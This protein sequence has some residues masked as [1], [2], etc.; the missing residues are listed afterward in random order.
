MK[1]R[2]TKVFVLILAV[3][4]ALTVWQ[5]MED[6]AYAKD[7]DGDY[8]II[9][10]PG[11]GGSDAGAVSAITNDNE[12]DL[13]WNIA[14]ALKAELQ[15]YSGVKVY[16]TRGSAEF[17]SNVG[18]AGVGREMGADYLISV[19]NNSSSSSS[20]NGIVC[21]GTVISEYREASKQMG[22][23]I[24]AEVNKLGINLYSGGYATR[25]SS[26]S[27]TSDY[28]TFLGEASR[29]G[30]PSL[31]IEHCYI[32][33]PSDAAFVHE[34]E[35]QYK[36]GAADAT[37]IAKTL[38]LTKRGVMPGNSITLIRTYSAYIVDSEGATFKSSDESVVKVR[39]DGL[40]TAAGA[41]TAV[42]TISKNGVNKTV[43]VTVPEVEMV[44][45]SAGLIQKPY[46]S[47][48][49]AYAYDRN[50][51]IVKAIYSDGSA[52]Q[53]NDGYTEGE[54]YLG[55]PYDEGGGHIMTPVCRQISY[56]GF[57]A[58]LKF[59][60][61]STKGQVT[62]SYATRALVGTNKDIFLMPRIYSGVN[63][64]DDNNIAVTKETTSEKPSHEP[65]TKEETQSEENTESIESTAEQ[66]SE[67]NSES[68]A[69]DEEG[70]KS[71]KNNIWLIVICVTLVIIIAAAACALVYINNNK[72][73]KRRRMRRRR[74][75]R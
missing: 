13:N 19:H 23:A 12:K 7:K 26:Y 36:I 25:S 17:Q 1:F 46:T 8:V 33:N 11:H 59:Y 67:Q 28:Y 3:L 39:S 9:I 38:G 74:R 16:L 42:I 58:T 75:R 37:G 18:R 4:C 70:K 56:N 47:K 72:N 44:G 71:S 60:Y 66:N 41:G 57:N 51:T 52:V 27:S 64:N 34:L 53:I 35:N 62:T 10:D 30:I 68:N 22:L 29:S 5:C 55:A 73:K 31:I 2:F 65:D 24:A 21:Y 61:F 6:K 50:L 54:L 15:T 63:D 14:V 49:E 32:S 40:I 20:P 69:S 45:L 43:S 48:E